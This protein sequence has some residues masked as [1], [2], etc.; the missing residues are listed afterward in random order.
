M[1]LQ[2]AL[3]L[4]THLKGNFRPHQPNQ[5]LNQTRILNHKTYAKLHRT[6]NVY[7]TSTRIAYM[8]QSNPTT[9]TTTKNPSPS[10][11]RNA[12]EEPYHFHPHPKTHTHKRGALSAG[13]QNLQ[14]N[15]AQLATKTMRLSMRIRHRA[16]DRT[17]T[18][19][20]SSYR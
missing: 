11:V 5:N 20:T 14:Q 12:T 8:I 13:T 15:R 18:P 4:R 1:L 9:T 6:V 7:S 3:H 10:H 19:T 2:R 16:T 17:D